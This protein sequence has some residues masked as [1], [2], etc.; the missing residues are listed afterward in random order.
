MNNSQSHKQKTKTK[1]DTAKIVD[2]RI[3]ND[4]VSSAHFY[5]PEKLNTTNSLHVLKHQIEYPALQDTFD[6]IPS[7]DDIVSYGIQAN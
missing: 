4:E 2:N 3:T 1:Y 5:I 6:V 7:S